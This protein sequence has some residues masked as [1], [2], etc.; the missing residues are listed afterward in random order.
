MS[1]VKIIHKAKRILEIVWAGNVAPEEVDAI[2][3][4]LLQMVKDEGM[5]DFSLV[6]DM[7]EM[8]AFTPAARERLVEHQRDIKAA[9][10]SA[11]AVVVASKI[12]ELQ[13]RRA[14]AESQHSTE[15]HWSSY[16]EALQ[17]LIEKA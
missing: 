13:L 1:S 12:T 17:Y 16:E 8:K 5:N 7:R 14:A 4:E 15:T 11:A 9:G 10:L 2:N 6:V 3:A